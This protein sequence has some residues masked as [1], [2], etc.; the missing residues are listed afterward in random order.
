MTA[1]QSS[2]SERRSFLQTKFGSRPS[3]CYIH[4]YDGI[5]CFRPDPL[6]G[7]IDPQEFAPDLA[8]ATKVLAALRDLPAVPTH[9]PANWDEINTDE[10]I[11]LGRYFSK[12]PPLSKRELDARDSVMSPAAYVAASRAAAVIDV[13]MIGLRRLLQGLHMIVCSVSGLYGAWGQY[14]RSQNYI[15][16]N[17]DIKDASFIPPSPDL[18]GECMAEIEDYYDRLTAERPPDIADII[19]VGYQFAMVHPFRDANGRVLH[20]LIEILLRRHG[21][22]GP[23]PLLLRPVIRK[24]RYPYAIR[25]RRVA[26][27][28]EWKLFLGFYAALLREAAMITRRLY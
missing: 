4:L 20:L 9:L 26:T 5:Y 24:Y 14:R 23:G 3:G 16:H 1:Q 13:E 27:E 2:N 25:Y 21:L 19:C 22:I 12:I 8:D 28:S 7:R 6:V 10:V 11:D 17:S 18:L 15:S